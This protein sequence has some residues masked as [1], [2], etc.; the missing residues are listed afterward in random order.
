MGD[1]DLKS[2]RPKSIGEYGIGHVGLKVSDIK[3]S[4]RFYS[5]ILG[6]PSDNRR[7][8]TVRMRCG[9]DSLVI[10]EDDA[11]A[12]NFHF[13]FRLDSRSSVEEWKRWITN[14]DIRISDDIAEKDHP[15]SFK[16]RDPDGYLIEISSKT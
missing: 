14:N 16:F 12:S 3:K 8:G 10:Y 13:G 6:L 9:S 15:R 1:Q 2:T 5:K 4:R 11:G 7:S